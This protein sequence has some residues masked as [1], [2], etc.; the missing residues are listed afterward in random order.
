MSITSRIKAFADAEGL[1]I[2]Q[3]EIAIGASNGVLSKPISGN[4]DILTKWVSKIIDT[5]PVNVEWLFT[6]RGAM[7]RDAYT[8]SPNSNF[9]YEIEQQKQIPPTA[10]GGILSKKLSPT[11]SPTHK[12][13]TKSTLKKHYKNHL[14][15]QR[16]AEPAIVYNLGAPQVIS[17]SDTGQD[18]IIYVPVKARAGYLDGYGDP[19]FI[20]T[21]PT[22][23][24]PGL[25]NA[26]FRMF[27]VEGPSMSPNIV[28]G[29]RIIGEWVES[30]DNIRD[31]RVHIVVTRNDGVVIKRVLNRIK[32]R[33]VIVLK[34]DTIAHR[35]EYQ[36]YQIDPSE[37]IEI[38][39]GRLKLSADLSEPAEI[40]RHVNDLEADVSEL[41]SLQDHFLQELNEIKAT[42]T[43]SP[44]LSKKKKQ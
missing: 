22:F 21:L 8:P 19:K 2:R 23:R 38:W 33:G 29:D 5:Y 13:D 6:G 11:L 42:F 25:N 43:R 3:L 7:L 17:V 44:Q 32:E 16:T 15:E 39:Y 20:Q 35:K 36:T 9:Q 18:N 27:E 34:S 14:T 30:L 31:N 37:I 1:S 10:Q 12:N 28:H 40:Y 41:R 26:S 4:T 24:L